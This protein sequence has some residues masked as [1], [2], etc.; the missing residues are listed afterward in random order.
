MEK[1]I[2]LGCGPCKTPGAIGFDIHPYDGVDVVGN[3]N[4]FPWPFAD[5]EFDRVICKQV[6]EHVENPTAF[7]KELHRISKNSAEIY[8][9][10]PHYTCV[11]SWSDPT[12]RWH[13]SAHWFEPF[14]KGG[15]L[16]AQTGYFEV[17][18]T[19]VN[20]GKNIRY[21]IPKLMIKLKG[22]MFWEKNYGFIYPARDVET[23]LKVIK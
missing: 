5:N 19:K 16:G 9:R 15:Y 23:V 1:V 11:T 17:I 18:S 8:V 2:D 7:F 21:L 6:V 4:S 13:Y 22:L 20:F 3:L 14:I 12:H 10:T